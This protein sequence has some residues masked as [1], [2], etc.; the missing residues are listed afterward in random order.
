MVS[1]DDRTDGESLA[2]RR[3]VLRGLGAATVASVG[4]VGSSTAQS[5]WSVDVV[6]LRES[7]PDPLP[8]EDELL[9]FA[10]GWL[11]TYGA[12]GQATDLAAGLQ[13]ADHEVDA[14]VAIQWDAMTLNFAG[15]TRRAHEAGADIAALI[16]TYQDDVGGTIRLV[17]HSLGGRVVLETLTTLS[18]GYS[19]DTVAPMGAAADGSTVTEGGRWYDGVA[20]NAD[21]VRNY[22]SEDDSTVGSAYGGWSDTA[23][24]AEGVPD[25]SAT[26]D[27]YTDVDL[28][29]AV[30]SHTDFTDNQA[31]ADDLADAILAEDDEDDGTDEE[32]DS[33]ECDWCWWR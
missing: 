26:P 8:A 11:A 7:T 27:T 18:E 6:D 2:T 12:R 29:H 23:L 13:E 17:G 21:A 5:R 31:V 10:H 25:A 30:D 20:E 9:V 14:T 28:T 33:D 3:N 19:V 15:A 1:R 32:D 4:V 24:G 22:H 16:E